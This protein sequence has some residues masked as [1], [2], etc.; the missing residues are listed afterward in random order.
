[1]G[2]GLLGAVCAF[3]FVTK[4]D[5]DIAEQ[6][7]E[8]P[9][10]L[11]QIWF[12]SEQDCVTAIEYSAIKE[13]R[14]R[15]V[16]WY[17]RRAILIQYPRYLSQFEYDQYG[18]LGAEKR[19]IQDNFENAR[20]CH[21]EHLEEL[22]KLIPN[23]LYAAVQ[24]NPKLIRYYPTSDIIKLDFLKKV[25]EEDHKQIIRCPE[26]YI[27]ELLASLPKHLFD[28]PNN[29]ID[30]VLPGPVFKKFFGQ[31]KHYKVTSES[32]LHRG[33]QLQYGLVVDH[34][35]FDKKQQCSY[36]IHFSRSPEN[37]V[38]LYDSCYFGNGICHLREVDAS[39]ASNVRIGRNT[40]KA[41]RVFLGQPLTDNYTI[42][43]PYEKSNDKQS[44]IRK[45][46]TF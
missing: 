45:P 4:R 31:F 27:D 16:P 12:P 18:I 8:K 24:C 25:V 3:V 5:R 35:P 36:G 11:D 19:V 30:L 41:D 7:K 17:H 34:Q 40:V 29:F 26:E 23:R 43:F 20:F 33:L 42:S 28:D 1:L 32:E 14:I 10:L 2:F 13:F 6:L 44:E 46:P 38:N 9:Y 39:V 22:A 21:D 15:E 37:Y